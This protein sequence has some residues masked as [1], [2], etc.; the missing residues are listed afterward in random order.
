MESGSW[1]E[2]GD[3]GNQSPQVPDEIFFKKPSKRLDASK[4]FST[5]EEGDYPEDSSL[6]PDIAGN[7][8]AERPKA[9]DA[10]AA[11]AA[12]GSNNPEEPV[13]FKKPTKKLNPSKFFTTTENLSEE[14][15]EEVDSMQVL[16]EAP[17]MERS[18]QSLPPVVPQAPSQDAGRASS[19]KIYLSNTSIWDPTALSRSLD[20]AGRSIIMADL[21]KR[22]QAERQGK[23]KKNYI[24]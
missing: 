1:N 10:R 21:A 16:Q 22:S 23:K 11:A 18:S 8:E 4:F 14:S 17:T 5:A 13:F 19:S 7:F 20:F 9:Q 3:A 24:R 2:S 12:S 6:P 15:E